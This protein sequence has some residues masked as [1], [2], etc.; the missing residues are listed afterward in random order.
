MPTKNKK[1]VSKG[2]PKP[3]TATPQG[4]EVPT[5]DRP[6]TRAEK[7][8]L[9]EK[10]SP[11]PIDEI[12][13]LPTPVE[14]GSD[15]DELEDVKTETKTGLKNETKNTEVTTPK[16]NVNQVNSSPKTNT[17]VNT[18][19]TE[20]Q[21]NIGRPIIETVE[22]DQGGSL[23]KIAQTESVV[24]QRNN[25]DNLQTSN[26]NIQPEITDLSRVNSQSQ[27][28]NSIATSQSPIDQFIENSS[29]PTT[30]PETT[31][32]STATQ[33][34]TPLPVVEQVNEAQT[35]VD[36]QTET[37]APIQIPTSETTAMPTVLNAQPTSTPKIPEEIKDLSGQANQPNPTPNWAQPNFMGQ[38]PAN[39]DKKS[40]LLKNILMFAGMVLGGTLL[41]MIG[42]FTAPKI[43]NA[44][45]DK[46]TKSNKQNAAA[47]NPAPTSTPTPAP[48]PS[49]EPKI[50]LT[51][52]KIKILNGSGKKGEATRAK[53]SLEDLEFSSIS[54][55]NADNFDYQDTE[56]NYKPE[57]KEVFR[58]LKK[59]L[60]PSYNVVL[61]KEL[62]DN[63]K[64]DLYIVLGSKKAQADETPTASESANKQ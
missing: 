43:M 30:L 36:Y 57:Y 8:I 39:G 20:D 10:K 22:D 48:T 15:D 27:T 59:A 21:P 56:I 23:P 14:F 3:A 12:E 38:N 40:G 32:Q 25:D 17:Q 7:I 54:T 53:K 2:L 26:S 46:N 47:A 44:K 18:V 4:I 34:E 42:Y 16:H 6:L 49:P 51:S 64:Y 52:L 35:P 60:S 5:P 9:E 50:D 31:P 1:F 37:Q 61:G 29:N 33:S 58:D 24:T 55:G 45:N 19:K 11:K 13:A 28:P 41:V 63:D 62:K